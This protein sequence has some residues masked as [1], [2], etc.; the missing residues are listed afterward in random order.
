MLDFS[1]AF[2]T[3]NHVILAQNLD[4]LHLPDHVHN[5]IVNFLT[6]RTQSVVLLGKLSKE[7]N[8]I[9]QS[10]I[11]GSGL[12]PVLYAIYSSDLKAI[13]NHSHSPSEIC[14]RHHARPS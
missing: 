13:G 12:G 5:W 2:D 9:T 10:I 3:I 8:M 14:R 4:K 7:Q 1:K 11:Q 6:D